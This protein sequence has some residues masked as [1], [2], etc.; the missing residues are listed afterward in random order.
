MGNAHV[1]FRTHAISRAKGTGAGSSGRAAAY[2]T[3]TTLIHE[4]ARFC[5]VSLEHRKALNKGVVTEALRQ[6]LQ[7]QKLFTA[8]LSEMETLRRKEISP[9]LRQMFEAEGVTLSERLTFYVS[10]NGITIRDRG[11]APKAADDPDR[12][13]RADPGTRQT[14][15][16]RLEEGQITVT[17]QGG[18]SISKAAI[19]EKDDKRG[20]WT[21]RDG[22]NIYQIREFTRRTT[23]PETGKREVAQ[24]GLDVFGDKTFSYSKKKGVLESW[25]E[26]PD[27]AP[28][29]TKAIA[30]K[31]TGITQQDLQIF[32]N[33]V[34]AADPS[35]DGRPA[36]SYELGFLRDLSL[37]QNKQALRYFTEENFT[38]KGLAVLASI[39]EVQASDG[40]P[41][42]HVHL[43]VPSRPWDA[44]GNFT[45]KG[46]LLSNE[47][48]VKEWRKSWTDHLR[49]QLTA[50]GIEGVQI[51]HRSYAER[52]IE[53]TPGEHLGYEANN[54]EK[55]GQESKR[56]RH[57][58]RVKDKNKLRDRF[59]KH[60]G[61]ENPFLPRGK[62]LPAT[63]TLLGVARQL[64][65][66]DG[67]SGND[68]SKPK[69]PQVMAFS[70]YRDQHTIRERFQY[71]A[72]K[73]PT[74]GQKMRRSRQENLKRQNTRHYTKF[75]NL[76]N[77]QE[78]AEAI[79][80]QQ[81]K[82]REQEYER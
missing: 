76:R 17:R 30:A 34:E 15:R 58:R 60:P 39:H 69:E 10:Q 48:M 7:E 72:E 21:I 31:G 42:S 61:T 80:R 13:R 78:A 9:E 1:H 28:D 44:E 56:G 20:Y 74:L 16:L 38:D 49:K 73:K 81:E 62:A 79:K 37:E 26:V 36:Q 19:A 33:Q 59:R 40:K 11:T 8:P 25:L 77:N 23:N 18:V 27:N 24:K 65:D 6:E 50:A 32:M 2:Q 12:K 51:D 75:A 45:S 14:Y 47:R 64:Q 82:E 53:K 52:G 35:R 55:R 3:A 63:D 41:N 22:D 68:R 54:M 70:T 67:E 4:A 71:L 29:H 66:S 43:L 57:N 5:S 46:E